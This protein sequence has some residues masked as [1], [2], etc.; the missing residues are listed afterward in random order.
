VAV[1][2]AGGNAIHA[3][4]ALGKYLLGDRIGVRGNLLSGLS[5]R[6]KF[7][8]KEAIFEGGA[9]IGSEDEI[10]MR[11]LLTTALFGLLAVVTLSAQPRRESPVHRVLEDLH[12]VSDRSFVDE[13]RRR[14]FARAQ[15]ELVRFERDVHYEHEFDTGH[16][17]RA[18]DMLSRLSHSRELRPADRDIF[19]RD[20]DML[21]DFRRYGRT[22]WH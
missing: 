6:L 22:G 13:E 18:I 4:V 1:L 19:R 8:R 10:S 12:H 3:A 2:K 9:S 11:Y 21:R 14:E 16:I 20:I 5:C 15:E 17:D 7:F